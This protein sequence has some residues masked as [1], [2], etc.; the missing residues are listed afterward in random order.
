[1]SLP[2]VISL[3][4]GAAH[5]ELVPALGGR[6]ASCVLPRPDHPS[7]APT[8]VLHPFPTGETQVERWAKGGIYPL[9]PYW[10]L[11]AQSV[12][13]HGDRQHALAPYPEVAPHTLHGVAQRRPWQ[14]QN[15]ASDRVTLLHHHTA[16]GHWPWPFEALLDVRLHRFELEVRIALRNMSDEVVPA[17]IGLHPYLPA[18]AQSVLQFHAPV[19]WEATPDCLALRP[20]SVSRGANFAAGRALGDATFMGLYQRWRSPLSLKS[21]DGGQLLLSASDTLDH[22]VVHQPAGTPYLCIEPVSHTAD[23]FNLHARHVPDTGT[24]LLAPGQV[25]AGR[26]SLA[27]AA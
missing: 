22:L 10:G 4:N 27:W 12:L 2:T 11:I 13:H 1:M 9:V 24:R 15:Q 25:L 26:M 8:A 3:R 7:E 20:T 19:L 21:T 18:A 6:I 16:D 5:A 17:G 23:A 14:V